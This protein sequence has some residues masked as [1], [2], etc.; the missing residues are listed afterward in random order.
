M[1]I[2]P[3][4]KDTILAE[5]C[6][7]SGYRLLAEDSELTEQER[8]M[9]RAAEIKVAWLKKMMTKGLSAQ[10]AYGETGAVGFVEYMPIELSNFHK[11]KDLYVINCMVAPHTPPF[12]DPLQVKR[13]PG[14][15][16]A[17]VEAMIE[18]VKDK[19]KG[20]VTPPGFAYTP[21][22]K[23]FFAKFGFEEF[24]TQGM[25]MLIKRFES[26]ELPS[27]IHYEKK[28]QFKQVP[29]KLVIDVFWSSICPNMGPW[30]LLNVNDAAEEFGDRVVINDIC[31]DNPEVLKEYGIDPFTSSSTIFFD[32]KPMFAHPG[33]AEKEEIREALKKALEESTTSDN[34][35]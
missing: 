30:Q 16:S 35:G 3:L 14:C 13:V 11:G 12:P 24:E 15:G 17:L 2:K 25:K 9:L 34:R 1:E 20:I 7:G 31:T 18:D 22:M 27:P 4:G 19:C 8:T 21:D 10:I 6:C 26:V 33:P 5:A 32:G 29:G 23:G 28:Y